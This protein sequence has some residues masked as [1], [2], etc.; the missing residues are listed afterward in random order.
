MNTYFTQNFPSTF[1]NFILLIFLF[2]FF[3]FVF[4]CK[5]K[6][7]WK[8]NVTALFSIR[9]QLVG[10]KSTTATTTTNVRLSWIRL[11]LC[12]PNNKN[13]EQAI[14][15]EFQLTEVEAKYKNNQIKKWKQQQQKIAR[16]HWEIT[17]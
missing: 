6:V 9:R 16:A 5:S 15:G 7:T 11:S 12:S 8:K 1:L 14:G 10:H 2:L 13:I 3:F 4:D 17:M